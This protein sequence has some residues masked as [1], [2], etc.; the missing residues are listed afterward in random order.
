MKIVKYTTNDGHKVRSR[1]EVII[2]NLLYD[3]QIPHQY[4][5]NLQLGGTD[6]R[7][8]WFLPK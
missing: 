5:I 6:L 7:P 1:A 8:D 2:D 4:E 3:Q